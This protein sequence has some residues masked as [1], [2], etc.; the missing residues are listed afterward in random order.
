MATFVK[1]PRN[2]TLV[3]QSNYAKIM[4]VI[5]FIRAMHCNSQIWARTPAHQVEINILD[6]TKY[7]TSFSFLIKY[8]GRQKW[9]TQ[10]HITVRC[11]H[12]ARVAEVINFQHHKHFN[13]RYSYP[14]PQMYQ[15][16]EKQQIN[17]FLGEWMNYCLQTRCTFQSSEVLLNA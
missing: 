11:Y 10:I 5:P 13:A 3:H 9:L 16:N 14:N 6:V 8:A 7:T 4:R 12:D 1:H 15:R 17:A 2:S